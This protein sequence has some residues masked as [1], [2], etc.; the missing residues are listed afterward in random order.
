MH[1]FGSMKRALQVNIICDMGGNIWVNERAFVL[2]VQLA[3]YPAWHSGARNIQHGYG[4][5]MHVCIF[6]LE[7]VGVLHFWEGYAHTQLNTCSTV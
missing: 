3:I 2:Y 5:Y 6:W 1:N 4:S 7:V